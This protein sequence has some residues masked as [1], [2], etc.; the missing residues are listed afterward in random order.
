AGANRFRAPQPVE[1]WTGVRDATSFGAPAPQVT[2][3]GGVLGP[4]IYRAWSEDCLNLNVSTPGCDGARRP[5]MVW[6]HG[7]S[8]VSGSGATPMYA[9]SRLARRGDVV[10]VTINYRLG[11][12]GYVAHPDLADPDTGAIGNFGVLDQ[13]AAL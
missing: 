12:L 11:G 8:F 1:P 10:V 4:S 13:L 3:D 7:G 2:S 9:G 6:I 5:V